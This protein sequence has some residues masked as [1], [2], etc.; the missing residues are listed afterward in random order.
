M[1]FAVEVVDAEAAEQALQGLE[2][3][4]H[5]RDPA[6][7]SG[8]ARIRRCYRISGLV[9]GVGFRPFAYSL[10][11]E[12]ALA[13][14]ERF[15]GQIGGTWREAGSRAL[16]HHSF[17]V[18]EVYPW[19]GLLRKTGNPAALNVL[20]RCRIR[21]ATVR[22]VSDATATVSCRPLVTFGNSITPGP[23]REEAAAFLRS[24][25]KD[26]LKPGDRVALHWDWVCDVLDDDQA[27][28]IE[29]HERRQLSFE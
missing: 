28:L 19:A 2:L 3:M 24:G 13:G 4:G 22:E 7:A 14:R 10:A 27:A 18:F 23:C 21:V 12:L 1:G 5:P 26:E 15:A 6:P 8:P 29:S 20:D 17:H 25:L 16:A 9:Q 11:A